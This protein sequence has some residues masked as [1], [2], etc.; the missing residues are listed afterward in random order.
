MEQLTWVDFTRRS[1]PAHPMGIKYLERNLRKFGAPKVFCFWTKAPAIVAKMYEDIVLKMQSEGCMVLAQIT[2]N[3]YESKMEPIQHERTL[4]GPL[5]D[6]LGDP[7][8]I[9]LRFDPIIPGYTQ[10]GHFESCV[11]AAAGHGIDQITTNFLVPS[12]KGVGKLLKEE[13]YQI[14]SPSWKW[15]VGTLRTLVHEARKRNVTVAGCAELYRD[16][17]AQEVPGLRIS[18]CSDPTWATSLNPGLKDAFTP[19]ASRPGCQCVYTADWG[20]YASRGGYRCP[21]N[22]LY[23]YAK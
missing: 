21:H 14:F 20:R 3:G 1:D 5:A 7:K 6:L 2:L 9:R 13:G 10:K 8:R 18:G 15:K 11:V 23:C 19:R 17:I 22:C 16:K 4:I 12:Y